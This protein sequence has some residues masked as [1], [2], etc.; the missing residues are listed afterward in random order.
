MQKQFEDLFQIVR[1]RGPVVA[2]AIHNGHFTRPQIEPY[3]ALNEAERLREEDPFTS[4]LTEVAPTR[5]IGLRSRFEFDLNR[6]RE[7]AI[8]RR[9][10]DSWGLNVWKVPLP[11]RLVEHSLAEYDRFYE[12]AEA[13]I[14]RLVKIHRRVV[15]LDLHTYNHRRDG[16]H[17]PPAD[18][19]EN[20]EINIG[21]GS[22]NRARWTPVVDRFIY[23]LRNFDFL[24][25][26]LDVRENV[27]FR[28][29]YFPRWLHETFPDS[30]C[31]IAVEFKKFFMDEWTG[32]I[33]RR[34]FRA[35]RTALQ[36]TIPGLLAALNSYNGDATDWACHADTCVDLQATVS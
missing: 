36:S 5:L 3:L 27:K 19:R 20:P 28:G 13:V 12:S 21:T 1:G 25:R 18:E 29:G 30:V 7:G 34:Q 6:P 17:K 16:R 2:A 31:A 14:G 26:H 9:P 24:G 15:V 11:A 22:M 8:Y 4:N 35:L 23:D 10:A 32:L 33:D